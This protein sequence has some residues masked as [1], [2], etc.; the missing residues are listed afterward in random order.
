MHNDK[1][2]DT[3]KLAG[4][5]SLGTS[6]NQASYGDH[7]H[8]GENSIDLLEGITITG[9]RTT[10]DALNNLLDALSSLGLVNSTTP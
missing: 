2:Q 6:H 5:H 10:G 4:H 1:D 8:N 3:S 9:S 7:T